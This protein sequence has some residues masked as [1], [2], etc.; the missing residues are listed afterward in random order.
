MK[1]ILTKEQLDIV[2]SILKEDVLDDIFSK[3]GEYLNK[4]I[5][6]GKDLYNQAVD[7]GSEMYKDA[8]GDA[9]VGAP[10]KSSDVPG[11]ADTVGT[12][13]NKFFEILDKF[14]GELKQQSYG[15]M[16]H[17]QEVEAIQIGLS[18]LGHSLPRFGVDGLFGP[19]T[20]IAVNKYKS[21]K[22]LTE[23][24]VMFLTKGQLNEIE[25]VTLND[26]NYSHVKFDNDG[27][28]NDSV[29][30]ALL[31]DI[32]TAA[33]A[34][35]IVATI[36]TAVSGHAVHTT[37]GNI[38]RH[39]FGVAADIAILNG[40][41]TTATNGVNGNKEFRELGNQLKDA[42]VSLGYV[43]N[44]ET[45][46][47]KAVLW[48]TDTGGNHYNHLHVS[49]KAGASDAE[50]T[51]GISVAGGAVIDRKFVDS[52]TSELKSKGV[53]SED[54]SKFVDPGTTT[55]GSASFTDLD[56]RTTDGFNDY[57]KICQNYIDTRNPSAFVTGEMM[58]DGARKAQEK[59]N[60]YVPPELALAQI[61]LEGGLLSDT[62]KVPIET[63]NPFNVGN[64]GKAK[65]YRN[66]FQAGV[67]AYYDLLARNYLVKGKTAAD[68]VNAFT[69]FEG[70]SYAE[71]GKYEEGLRELLKSI[72]KRN[73]PIYASLALNKKD[74]LSLTEA[75][76]LLLEADKRQ[77]IMNVFGLKKEWADE[78]HAINDKVSVWIADSYIKEQIKSRVAANEIPEGVDPKRYVIDG[79][80]DRGPRGDDGW[81]IMYK[82][83]YD[84][85]NHWIKAP[86]RNEQINLKELDYDT[87]HA[88]AEQWHAEVAEKQRRK[89]EKDTTH[90]YKEKK[91]VFIDMR[92]DG[93][94]GY[95]W[96]HLNTSYCD[97]EHAR[98]GHCARS[99]TGQLISLRHIDEE[100]KGKSLL[101]VDYRPGGVI[102]DFHAAYNDKPPTQYHPQIIK[103]L[104]NTTYPVTELATNV[105]RYD[106]NFHLADLS[107]EDLNFVIQ[108]NP[109]LKYNFSNKETWPTIIDAIISGEI[110]PSRYSTDQ[111]LKLLGK[112]KD[113]DKVLNNVAVKS[114]EELKKLFTNEM[115]MNVLNGRDAIYDAEVKI[116]LDAFGEQLINKL[117]SD[118]D[119]SNSVEDFISVLRTITSRFFSKYEV[120]CPYIDYGFN[121][122]P[123]QHAHIISQRGFRK[124]LLSC[125][126]SVEFLHR[127]DEI[128]P[129][130]KCGNIAV[131]TEDGLWGLIKSTGETLLHPQF[132]GISHFGA[133]PC[134]TYFIKT[135][136][137]N[138]FINI[139]TGER[140]RLNMK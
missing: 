2:E 91:Q 85:I 72:R 6:V 87:A 5:E 116:Y 131:R 89:V 27:T 39:G 45:G 71:A 115:I 78:F 76:D 50:L 135:N 67:D 95:Y 140:T 48:Q 70:N 53:T 29:N 24:V 17:Q 66:T 123:D 107:R 106:D 103:F 130:D 92:N 105:H 57:A 83:G 12:D 109:S 90:F 60:K 34:V 114:Y 79:M 97:E 88:Q 119:A 16:K 136:E 40:K 102:G 62:S 55:G 99:N 32:E 26:T 117:Q 80:N 18:L 51:A 108:N 49:N 47:S 137:G 30:Q 120:F 104:V 121:K 84:Y 77:A 11:L 112:A 20:A 52:I 138:M 133:K 63:K 36:T 59:Y 122:F 21:E 3:G 37:T 125:T 101:T 10:V 129:Q 82:P 74:T 113:I 126:D 124:T 43:W 8:T 56:T 73:A 64:T 69:N 132:N 23:A 31:D 19:E 127:Y 38:S 110:D 61:T 25:M 93:G 15:T 118:L 22:N 1:V 9:K 86:D 7:A 75:Y 139:E 96:V 100:G 13:V 44:T 128:L 14:D 134:N 42:L 4:G 58:A 65:V 28:K 94:V 35:G 98:M 33:S 68:L 81:N 54:L 46:N 111:L 41:S